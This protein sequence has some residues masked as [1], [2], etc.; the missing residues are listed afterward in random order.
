MQTASFG[1]WIKRIAQ[2]IAQEVEGEGGEEDH[3]AGREDPVF[4]FQDV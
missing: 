4:R 3:E 1:F 2:P